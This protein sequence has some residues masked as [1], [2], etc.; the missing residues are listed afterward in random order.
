MAK[1]KEKDVLLDHD[2]DG[3]KELDNDLPPWW[4]YL[5]YVTIAF[6]IIY[7][8]YFHVFDLGD[9]SAEKYKKEMNPEWVSEKPADNTPSFGF[10]SPWKS[11]KVEITPRLLAEF[12]D[13]IGD[14]V[15]FERLI[16]EAKRRSSSDQLALLNDAFPGDE[17]IQPMET[18]SIAEPAQDLVP[19]TDEENLLAGKGIYDK[20][21]A[22]CH[23]PDGGGLI[24]PNFTDQ[25]WIH[26]GSMNDIVH[27]INVGVPAKGMIPWDKTLTAEQ[28]SQVASF[29]ITL[30]GSTPANPKAPEGEIYKRN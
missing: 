17:L 25:N 8:L 23:V 28:I 19:Y 15:T 27:L 12:Q 26:G 21:C 29:I 18:E 14:D 11:D 20:N 9:S 6:A 1:M 7:M 24:G 13:Y 2:Y 16:V 3:I 5:F 4:L 10:K 30:E 22:V